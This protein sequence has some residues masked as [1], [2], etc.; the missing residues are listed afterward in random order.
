MLHCCAEC[1]NDG[2]VSLKT[3]K[4]CKLVKYCNAK[5]QRNHWPKHKKQCKVRAAELRDEALYKDPP[6]KEEEVVLDNNSIKLDIILFSSN[7]IVY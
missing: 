1:G 2:G 3:C 6:A 7:Q 4:S 5:C